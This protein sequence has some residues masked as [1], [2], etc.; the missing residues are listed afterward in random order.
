MDDDAQQERRYTAQDLEEARKE[1]LKQSQEETELI[2][3]E[4]DQL[5]TKLKKAKT[6][7]QEMAKLVS[8][9]E[10]TVEELVRKEKEQEELLKQRQEEGG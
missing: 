6:K 1:G 8:E 7:N 9:Y 5:E 4:I 10:A 2:M 3:D